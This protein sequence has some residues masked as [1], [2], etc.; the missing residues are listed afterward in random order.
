MCVCVCVTMGRDGKARTASRYTFSV[1]G[2]QAAASFLAGALYSA[3]SSARPGHRLTRIAIACSTALGSPR[4]NYR[5]TWFE[6]E[7][8]GVQTKGVGWGRGGG[9][10]RVGVGVGKGGE[11]EEL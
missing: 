9:G 5:P 8:V 3:C 6:S 7:G 4:F 10:V 11:G 1:S 2:D